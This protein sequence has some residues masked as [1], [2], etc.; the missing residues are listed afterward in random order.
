MR[1]RLY[2]GL[3]FLKVIDLL[4]L[5]EK[6]LR[7]TLLIVLLPEDLIA[8]SRITYSNKRNLQGLSALA[9]A[10]LSD[11]EKELISKYCFP[12]GKFLVLGCGAG[13]ETYDL[14]KMGFTVTGIDFTEE[15][16]EK[17]RAVAEK[18]QL[19]IKYLN[20]EILLWASRETEEQYN[21]IFLSNNVY[22]QIP[23]RKRRINFIK[24]ILRRLSY[25][26]LFIIIN[27]HIGNLSYSRRLF[28]F[29]R[30][31][32]K[33]T[34]GNI[35][36]EPGDAIPRRQFYHCPQN[37]DEFIGEF[38]KFEDRVYKIIESRNFISVLLRLDGHKEKN[39]IPSF[40][41]G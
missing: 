35:E 7:N 8:L 9:T 28:K 18:E 31:L 40:G 22:L 12:P 23:T 21:Y 39:E 26:G 36:I 10:G 17:A 19:N 33:L 6:I 32:A 34:F 30:L 5:A 11:E 3:L 27:G 37:K 41:G 38:K 29:K 1:I 15:L 2:I 20:R 24:G 13:R 14:A 25:H 16:L 4:K